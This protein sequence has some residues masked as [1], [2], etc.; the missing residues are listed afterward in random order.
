MH[1]VRV[2]SKRDQTSDCS[3]FL[4]DQRKAR[5][6]SE[7]NVYLLGHLLVDHGHKAFKLRTSTYSKTFNVCQ[8]PP[9]LKQ[10]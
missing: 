5:I 6:I 7:A 9:S 2:Q 4:G 10:Q 8:I 1:S 3:V